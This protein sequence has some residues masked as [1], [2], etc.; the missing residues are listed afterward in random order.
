[1]AH[2]PGLGRHTWQHFCMCPS[3]VPYPCKCAGHQE[4]CQGSWTSPWLLRLCCNCRRASALC[5]SSLPRHRE[6]CPRLRDG[7]QWLPSMAP[8]T[9]GFAA[10]TCLCSWG[11]NPLLTTKG[12]FLL[13]VAPL[14]LLLHL[15]CLLLL[16][17]YVNLQDS[18]SIPPC[19]T[20]FIFSS[21]S[22]EFGGNRSH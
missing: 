4:Q 14:L 18:F 8:L 19:V 3:H 22:S 7:A 2:F 20:V 13:L 21:L 10:S 5:I 11:A 12:I 17:L 9:A 1:M 6:R 16:E 15:S